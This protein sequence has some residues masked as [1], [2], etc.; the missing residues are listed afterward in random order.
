[1][2]I[3]Y[4][5]KKMRHEGLH[6]LNASSFSRTFITEKK[7]FFLKSILRFSVKIFKVL[8]C[9]FFYFQQNYLKIIEQFF[10]IETQGYIF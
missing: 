7:T 8:G 10:Y 5:N 9:F 1:M 6:S 4:R 2:K 3:R